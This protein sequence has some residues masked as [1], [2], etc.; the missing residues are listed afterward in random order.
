MK[1]IVKMKIVGN[2]RT[3]LKS[4]CHLRTAIRDASTVHGEDDVLIRI[5]ATEIKYYVLVANIEKDV[6]LGM[7]IIH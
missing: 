2:Q 4:R 6:I 5:G 3:L 1:T 7:D